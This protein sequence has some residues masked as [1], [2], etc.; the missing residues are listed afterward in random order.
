MSSILFSIRFILPPVIVSNP[1]STKSIFQG[2]K[3]NDSNDLTKAE[4]Y[5]SKISNKLPGNIASSLRLLELLVNDEKNSDAL[6]HIQTLQQ[7]LPNLSDD[8]NNLI[9]KILAH[10]H[11][12]D[13]SKAKIPLIMLH[14][15]LK[16]LN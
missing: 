16:N 7:T 12:E 2:S 13:A 14:N 1:V 6:Y 8:S 9:R 4:H 10:L 3:S 5:F 15:I 11:N